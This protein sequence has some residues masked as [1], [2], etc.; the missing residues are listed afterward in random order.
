MSIPIIKIN[1][2]VE[3]YMEHNQSNWGDSDFPNVAPPFQNF[4]IE[5]ATPKYVNIK[6]QRYENPLAGSVWASLWDVKEQVINGVD[7]WFMSVEIESDVN[8]GCIAELFCDKQGVLT[9]VFDVGGRTVAVKLGIQ[10]KFG[11]YA[12]AIADFFT[13]IIQP[14]LLALSFMHCKNVSKELINPNDKLPRHVIKHWEKKGK[15]L[16][17]KHYILNIEPMKSVLKGEGDIDSNGIQKA[18]HICRGHFRDY[19]Q[20]KGLFGKYHGMFWI[21]SHVKGSKEKGEVEKEYNIKI[22]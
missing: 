3:Y 21:E 22:V 14:Q 2:V 1:N 19:T 8:L 16:L 10:P 11:E 15:P 12:P 13:M 6:G 7:G 18:M 20:G 4:K 5:F 9:Q 17:D